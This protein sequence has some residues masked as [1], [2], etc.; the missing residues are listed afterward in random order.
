MTNSTKQQDIKN[1]TVKLFSQA[2]VNK[3]WAEGNDA[4]VIAGGK[5]TPL[6]TVRRWIKSEGGFIYKGV[7]YTMSSS[8]IFPENR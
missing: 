4:W 5:E 6:T 8:C 7:A 3:Y 1:G 2:D